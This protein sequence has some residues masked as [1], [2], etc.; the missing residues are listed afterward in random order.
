M[1][2][3]LQVQPKKHGKHFASRGDADRDEFDPSLQRRGRINTRTTAT[4]NRG[5]CNR[6]SMA[7]E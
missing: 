5:F 3:A 7:Y 6:V 2:P 4:G 1:A